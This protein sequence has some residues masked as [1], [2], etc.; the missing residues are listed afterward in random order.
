ANDLDHLVNMG[1]NTVVI[2]QRKLGE[3]LLSG[4]AYNNE[5]A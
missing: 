1:A 5:S 3:S 2:K 4:K